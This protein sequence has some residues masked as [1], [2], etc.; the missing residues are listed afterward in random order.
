MDAH[1]PQTYAIIG[2]AMAVH[3]EL[4]PGFLEL[5]Y[6][7]ALEYEFLARSIPFA[8]EVP[9]PV[10]YRQ[11]RLPVSFRV[12]LVCFDEILVEIKG[13]REVGRAEAAQVINY[14][15]AGASFSRG[16]LINFGSTSLQYKRFVL[17]SIAQIQSV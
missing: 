4:G 13:I 11:Q 6:A 16:L 1:D 12:D 14:L 3:R 7:A 5:V 15:K 9:L 2:A 10:Y 17:S 8:R